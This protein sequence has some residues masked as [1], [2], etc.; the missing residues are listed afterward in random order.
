MM[1]RSNMNKMQKPSG[2]TSYVNER[3]E[4]PYKGQSGILKKPKY[5]PEQWL[6]KLSTPEQESV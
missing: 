3:I 4:A 2:Y 6:P 1:K 5:Q